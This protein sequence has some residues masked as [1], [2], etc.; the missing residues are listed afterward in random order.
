VEALLNAGDREAGFDLPKAGGDPTAA[1]SLAAQLFDTVFAAASNFKLHEQI[2][3]HGFSD[4]MLSLL[5]R[6]NWFFA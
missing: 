5:C 6:Y 2:C 1:S 3:T 4:I